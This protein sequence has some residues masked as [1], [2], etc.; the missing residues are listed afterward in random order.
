MAPPYIVPVIPRTSSSFHDFGRSLFV[1]ALRAPAGAL[2]VALHQV[3][4]SGEPTS[5]I[6]VGT[7]LVPRVKWYSWRVLQGGILRFCTPPPARSCHFGLT[8]L[9]ISR[10]GLPRLS[11]SC[12]ETF[13]I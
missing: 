9:V 5:V 13:F 11:L 3:Q 12:D 1:L 10:L 4:Y 7:R 8:V 6:G 2:T